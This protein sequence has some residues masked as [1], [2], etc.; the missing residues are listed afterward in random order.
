MSFQ[1][2]EQ[3]P[4]D[5]EMIAVHRDIFPNF[6]SVPTPHLDRQFLKE[7][8]EFLLNGL[9]RFRWLLVGLHQD[10]GDMVS[11]FAQWRRWR[12]DRYGD[13]PSDNPAS[14]YAGPAFY[15]EFMEF[16][17]STYLGSAL[18][19]EVISGLLDYADAFNPRSPAARAEITGGAGSRRR[20]GG[21]IFDGL[22]G[23]DVIPVV[24]DGVRITP[25]QSDYLRIID[26]L[27]EKLPLKSISTEGSATVATADLEGA[28]AQ[29]LQLSPHSSE[30]LSLC[31]G[32]STVAEVGGKYR[33][34]HEEVDGVPAELAC[35]VGIE[36][37]RRQGL[38]SLYCEAAPPPDL[39][40]RTLST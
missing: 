5:R 31:D 40:Q 39:K 27:R 21:A 12:R 23:P 35:V 15:S 16:L 2:W 10:S 24:R 34:L 30:I 6:Y 38:V 22:I 26:G 11:A 4:E 25:L 33:L 28:G 36:V 9:A 7:I 37:L 20:Q 29:V 3:D 32:M 19:P 1:G 18:A 13:F 14:Y 17:R 8:R